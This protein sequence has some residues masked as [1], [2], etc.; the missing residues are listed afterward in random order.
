MP[1]MKILSLLI[2]GF[3]AIAK[4]A[5]PVVSNV[6]ASQMP[7]TKF[8]NIYYNLADADGDLQTI[9]VRVS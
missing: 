4:A 6:S 2:L 7:G 3:C 8:V 9:E 5:P 1:V